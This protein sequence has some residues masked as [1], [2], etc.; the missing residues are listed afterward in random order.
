[1]ITDYTTE[2]FLLLQ[3]FTYIFV[4]EIENKQISVIIV[5]LATPAS[6][7]PSLLRCG[8]LQEKSHRC[9]G[10]QVIQG[11]GESQLH[12]LH[13]SELHGHRNLTRINK[14]AFNEQYMWFWQSLMLTLMLSELTTPTSLTGQ[15][16]GVRQKHRVQH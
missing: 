11:S 2:R 3:R 1:M 13:T 8:T 15:K 4:S 5:A 10:S 14:G 6:A 9:V 12:V 7:V 16:S